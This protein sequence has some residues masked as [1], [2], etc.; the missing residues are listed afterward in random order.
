MY[1]AGNSCRFS[2]T[3]VIASLPPEPPDAPAGLAAAAPSALGEQ[4]ATTTHPASTPER[5]QP[6]RR[7]GRGEFGER[8]GSGFM[9]TG[10]ESATKRGWGTRAAAE[11]WA[12]DPVADRLT[13]AQIEA[14]DTERTEEYFEG[15]QYAKVVSGMRFD[16]SSL[17]AT[18]EGSCKPTAVAFKSVEVVDASCKLQSVVYDPAAGTGTREESPNACEPSSGA[19]EQAGE[20]VALPG[21]NAQCKW[22]P[23]P[24]AGPGGM[25]LPYTPECTLL[26]SP[27]HAGTGRPLVAIRK[28][29]DLLRNAA[30]PL[31]G[32]QALDMQSMVTVEQAV[33][34]SV[35]TP[36]P[37]DK[38]RLPADAAAFPLPR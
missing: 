19:P 38:F 29:P 6:A 13:D 27:V 25:A 24:A 22:T 21:T 35:G 32:M 12:Y 16:P 1:L 33:Q 23:A 11:G 10:A 18:R 4:A 14:L 2:R 31:P 30:T 20:A 37:A 28:M 17:S 7:C 34:V 5:S 15:R 26:P 3:S 36:I 9:G 8:S